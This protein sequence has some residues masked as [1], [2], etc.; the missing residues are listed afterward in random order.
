MEISPYKLGNCCYSAWLCCECKQT[1]YRTLKHVTAEGRFIKA[2]SLNIQ[3]KVFIDFP[4]GSVGKES[5]WVHRIPGLIPGWEDPLEKEMATH[6]IF[7]PGK[8]HGQRTLVDNS[9]WGCKELDRTEQLNHGK[10]IING[11]WFFCNLEFLV[12]RMRYVFSKLILLFGHLVFYLFLPG[13]H[14]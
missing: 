6:S 5:D 12:T 9:P 14:V 8:S 7:L 10:V 11:I 4:G 13:R 3:S 1:F 2:K